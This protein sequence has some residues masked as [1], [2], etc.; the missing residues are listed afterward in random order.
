[1]K[2]T[3]IIACFLI[4]GCACPQ[5]QNKQER[6]RIEVYD[7]QGKVKEHAIIKDEHITIY[8]RDWKT[9]GYGKITD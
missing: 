4:A 6:K 7:T 3:L 9:K 2:L 8:D 1:M 5:V